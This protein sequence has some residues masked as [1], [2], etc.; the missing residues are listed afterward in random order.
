MSQRDGKKDGPVRLDRIL[1]GVLS[2]CGLS[3][4][5]AER[6]LL[7]VWPAIVGDRVAGHVRA[8]D[9]RDG[10]LLLAADHGAWRQEVTLLLPK[11]QQQC[12]ERFGEGTV[13]EIRWA[14][15]WSRTPPVDDG[16]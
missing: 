4:R 16:A 6:S 7:D 10:V 3:D 12:N 1:G 11:I 14:R 13:T 15:P 2:D 8:V 5:L 9:L